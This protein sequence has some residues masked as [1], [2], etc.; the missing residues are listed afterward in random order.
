MRIFQFSLASVLE[1][2]KA[3]AGLQEMQLALLVAELHNLEASQKRVAA[4]RTAAHQF[5]KAGAQINWTDLMALDS[6]DQFSDNQQLILTRRKE[7]CRNR[8]AAQQRKVFEARR[9]FQLLEKLRERKKAEWDRQSTAE[10]E[11]FA[12]EAYLSKVVRERAEVKRQPSAWP[13]R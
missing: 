10:Q 12:C 4:D 8:I 7:D 1:W 11:D 13:P 9:D 5:V 6:F 2:R 3:Q